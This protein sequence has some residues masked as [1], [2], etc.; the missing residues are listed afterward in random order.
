[1]EDRRPLVA[2]I[3][4]PGAALDMTNSKIDA[5]K[6]LGG[7]VNSRETGPKVVTSASHVWQEI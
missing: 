6:R 1:M 4:G 2:A 3:L 7:R 5:V